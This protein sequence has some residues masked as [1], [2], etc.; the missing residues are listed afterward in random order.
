LL[1]RFWAAI[2]EEPRLTTLCKT[3]L[4]YKSNQLKEG[5]WELIV[6]VQPIGISATITV[7]GKN[8]NNVPAATHT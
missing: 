1:L 2:K 4:T 6:D 7:T 5:S 8:Q 3:N